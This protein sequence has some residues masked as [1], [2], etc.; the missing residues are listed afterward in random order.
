MK[1]PADQEPDWVEIIEGK[2]DDGNPELPRRE[3]VAVDA[4]R[5]VSWQQ[6]EDEQQSVL[7]GAHLEEIASG[8][9]LDGT[10]SGNGEGTKSR[11]GIDVYQIHVA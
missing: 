9:P 4:C 2:D 11:H 3:I 1:G 6:D 5:V 8:K 10:D 7:Y